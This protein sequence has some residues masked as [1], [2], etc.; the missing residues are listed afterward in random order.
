MASGEIFHIMS[1][2]LEENHTQYHSHT[3]LFENARCEA[4]RRVEGL[5]WGSMAD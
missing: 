4:G 3:S 2:T 5:T 1:N